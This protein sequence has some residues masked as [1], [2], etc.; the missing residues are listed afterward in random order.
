M[1]PTPPGSH[2]GY[3][4]SVDSSPRSRNTDSWDEPLPV[5]GGGGGG[6]GGG[7]S[8]LRLMCSYGGHIV[9]R[10]HDKSLCYLGGD[11]RIVVVDRHSSLADLSAK[12]ARTLLDGRTF[13]LK[14]QLPN[15]DLDSLISVT[16]DED[17]DNMIEEYDRTSS[18]IKPSR[19]RL[20][21]F[22]TKPES[23]SS[24]G[25]LLDD[26]KSETWFV[27]ALN[28]ANILPR[29]LSAD[30]NSVNCLLGL[31]DAGPVSGTENEPNHNSS[32][33]KPLKQDI[34]SVPDSPM[35]ETASSF[36]STSSAP[37][38]SNLP[39]IRVHADGRVGGGLEEQ[40]SH[41]KM[42]EGFREGAFVGNPPNPPTIMTTAVGHVG[43][44][45]PPG[46]GEIPNRVLAEDERSDPGGVRKPPQ[47][48]LPQKA[49]SL[50]SA[51]PDAIIRDNLGNAVS[52]G[53]RTVVYQDQVPAIPSRER[54]SSPATMAPVPDP[55]RE[56]TDPNYRIPVQVQDQG[57]IFSMPMEHQQPQFVHTGAPHYV[58]HAAPSPVP[59]S[60]YYQMHPV[61]HPQ[62]HQQ[63]DPQYPMYFV[64]M[65]QNPPSVPPPKPAPSPNQQPLI[66]P[67]Y[68]E[69]PPPIYPT[70]AAPPPKPE[71]Y[72]TATAAAATATAQPPLIHVPDPQHQYVGYHQSSANFAYEYVDPVHAQIYY[73]Q[74]TSANLASQYQTVTSAVMGEAP[75]PPAPDVKQNR[76]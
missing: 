59:I 39:P 41:M 49:T 38:L 3:P 43:V 46:V 51:P 9:P 71:M 27:D 55:K 53:Q 68:K 31:D 72:R 50:D 54:S 62:Q 61:Q 35:L 47:M 22:P 26:S 30:S 56:L 21:L 10:P 66:P 73:T 17:L 70:R 24:I 2:H 48:P 20:F 60:S 74:P 13:T 65:R 6:G 23:A 67:N 42:E 44:M 28:G 12:L 11:T 4:D 8:K 37:N 58:H 16:T 25:S 33:H 76:A 40:F 15:E 29:G 57:V 14:Y 45:S 19:L 34:H 5:L 64:P 32:S 36:G 18:S 1:E 63:V 52:R 69:A 7:S 75:M